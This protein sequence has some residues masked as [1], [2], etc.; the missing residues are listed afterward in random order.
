MRAR[1]LGRGYRQGSLIVELDGPAVSHL[2]VGGT[3]DQDPPVEV[4]F[5][6]VILEAHAHDRKIR[7]LKIA[8][9]EIMKS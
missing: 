4:E 1:I 9:K 7:E 5:K 3:L 2:F 6:K 8:A